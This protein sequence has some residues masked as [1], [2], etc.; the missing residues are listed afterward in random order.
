[1]GDV[2][3]LDELVAVAGAK[4]LG[5]RDLLRLLLGYRDGETVAAAFTRIFPLD[6]QLAIGLAEREE[7]VA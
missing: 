5:E 3:T 4:G 1:V 2:T 7:S 6:G